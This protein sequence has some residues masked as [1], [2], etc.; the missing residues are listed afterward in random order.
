MK[1]ILI[2]LF[3]LV[4]QLSNAQLITRSFHE[5]DTLTIKKPVVVF[6]Q[7]DWCRACKNM[8]AKTFTNQEVIDKLNSDYYFISFDAESTEKIK[9]KNK[10]YTFKPT[11][12]KTGT[13]E[14]AESLGKYR[15]RLVYPTT[16]ILNEK[17][18]IIFQRPSM[19]RP[20]NF[21][22]LLNDLEAHEKL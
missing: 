16:V 14:L 21:I 4:A 22:K 12:K 2:I 9:F 18:E 7:T 8:K 10:I 13:H 3:I 20:K 1:N 15:N 5:I 17:L 19:L 6:L 11:G